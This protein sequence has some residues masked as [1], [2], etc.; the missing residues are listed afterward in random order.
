MTAYA[1]RA[2]RISSS[3]IHQR[4]CTAEKPARRPPSR[5]A[6]T[7]AS[8]PAPKKP[9]PKK[10]PPNAEPD[11]YYAIPPPRPPAVDPARIKAL[12]DR[13]SKLERIIRAATEE[14]GGLQK[15]IA[16]LRDN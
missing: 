3:W 6:R 16:G 11:L 4:S 2:V 13:A 5:G 1:H 12:E 7:A 14:L 10:T 15:D 8:A 9:A